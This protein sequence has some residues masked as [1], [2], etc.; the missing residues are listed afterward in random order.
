MKPAAL[1]SLLLAAWTPSGALAQ[2]VD[3]PAPAPS[4]AAPISPPPPP[5]PAETPWRLYRALG[6]PEWLRFGLDH[7]WRFEHLQHD[8]RASSS[9]N[10]TGLSIRTLVTAEAQLAPLALGIELQ[11]SRA[12][13]S[14]QTP[15]NT[16]I[17]DPLE[18]LQAYVALRWRGLSLSAGRLTLDVGSR[19]L[20]ARNEFRNTLNAFTG[21]D[22]QWTAPG[23]AL[24]RA[25]AVVP[26]VRLPT[27]ATE[28]ARNVPRFDRE[29]ANTLLW[30]LFASTAPSEGAPS[31]LD[32]AQLEGYLL[33]LHERDGTDAPSTNRRLFTQGLRLLRAPRAAQL[34]YQLEG[35]L[36]LGSSR[37]SSAA[38]D[39][40]DLVHRAG[41]LHATLGYRF[42]VAATPRLALQ[43]DYAS[44]DQDPGDGVQGRFDPLFGARRFDFGPTGLYGAFSRANLSSPSWRVE[45]APHARVELMLAHRLVWLASS[46]DAWPPAGLRDTSGAS[47][48]FVGNQLEARVRWTP[49]PKN[50]VLEVGG[51]YL[52]RGRFA[53]TAPGAR[54]LDALYGYT[55][56]TGSL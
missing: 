21:L 10:A 26:V 30:G 29:N 36:Q 45:A 9:G 51:A 40:T 18:L 31:L 2:A 24:V 35:I 52:V 12:Y 38:D 15:L 19:R 8:F 23:G 42:D 50:L 6:A 41:S 16:T 33:G 54:D 53:S 48:T 11:D 5:K 25:L 55:Q 47:G 3:N 13:A 20:V 34:D 27:D 4:T 14:A 43:Y 56:L 28:L 39:T 44:G 37:A 49:L 7:R 17:V 46:R 32:R 22:A 1:L